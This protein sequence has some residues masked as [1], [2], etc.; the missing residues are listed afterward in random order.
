MLKT[1]NRRYMIINCNGLIHVTAC[2]W[3]C[4]NG[5]MLYQGAPGS[6]FS[7]APL[8][9]VARAR[10]ERRICTSFPG[11][12]GM[13]TWKMFESRVSEMPFPKLWGEIFRILMVKHCNISEASLA[14]CFCSTR[15]EPIVVMPLGCFHYCTETPSF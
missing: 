15:S 8:I 9:E 7:K 11:V 4:F 13:L 3:G 2:P 1:A 14:N 5:V 10:V 6:K 12:Q